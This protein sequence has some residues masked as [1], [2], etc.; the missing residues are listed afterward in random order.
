VQHELNNIAKNVAEQQITHAMVN[1]MN[2]KYIVTSNTVTTS[3]SS[4]T[5]WIH[6]TLA[7]DKKHDA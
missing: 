2:I 5:H 7:S 3:H 6:Q 4:A 1:Q